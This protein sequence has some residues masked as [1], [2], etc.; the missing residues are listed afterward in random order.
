[1]YM[2]MYVLTSSVIHVYIS[3][4]HVHMFVMWLAVV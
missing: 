4:N 3:P 2:Y 1:M